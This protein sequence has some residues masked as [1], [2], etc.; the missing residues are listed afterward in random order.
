MGEW[1][2]CPLSSWSL[3]PGA[4]DPMCPVRGPALSCA[5][6]LDSIVV[7]VEHLKE[8][9]DWV[10]FY[11][12]CG[13]DPANLLKGADGLLLLVPKNQGRKRGA[14]ICAPFLTLGTLI[15]IKQTGSTHQSPNSFMFHY[16]SQNPLATGWSWALEAN[17]NPNHLQALHLACW[18]CNS[19]SKYLFI[20]LKTGRSNG[21]M[22]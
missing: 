3:L 7:Q 5:T 14:S 15:L 20:L 1:H 21:T 4:A 19:N 6:G 22:M 17:K 2:L 8:W 9:P 11:S 13:Y 18:F 12:I 16:N 10:Q